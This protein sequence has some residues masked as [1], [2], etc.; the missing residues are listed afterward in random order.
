MPANVGGG[1]PMGIIKEKDAELLKE[2]FSE[3][4]RSDVTLVFFT[5][6]HECMYCRETRGFL[7]ELEVLSDKI[8][9][10]V[11]DLLAD[12]DKAKE[13]DVDKIPAI[14]IEGEQDYGIR[15]FGMPMG[16]EFTVIVEDIIDV[17]WGTSEMDPE[18]MGNILPIDEKMHIQV[19]VSPTCPYCPQMVRS[20]HKFAMLNPSITADMVEMTEFP[21]LV[22]KYDVMGVPKTVINEEFS[23]EGAYPEKA[24]SEYVKVASQGKFGSR[25]K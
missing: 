10:K 17:S 15:Y 23:I 8:H 19:F 12:A 3:R 20:A 6:E 9:L 14:V 22:Q 1:L 11:Y 25:S 18:T 7:E 24:F 13:Y 21:Q 5:Q 2:T 16:Y 4:L